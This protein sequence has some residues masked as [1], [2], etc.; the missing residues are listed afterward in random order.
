MLEHVR[1][2]R[3]RPCW[4]ASRGGAAVL[5]ATFVASRLFR[6]LTE[7]IVV[8][9]ALGSVLFIHRM[10]LTTAL[11]TQVPLVTEEDVHDERVARGPM[12]ERPSRIRPW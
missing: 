1:A 10:S 8:G 6:G 9:F 4:G 3:L 11:E 5:L 12:T 7:A 2:R